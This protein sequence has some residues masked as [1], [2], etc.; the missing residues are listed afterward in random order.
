VLD[1]RN[2]STG[3]P[4]FD[5]NLPVMV[6]NWIRLGFVSVDYTKNLSDGSKYDWL[7]DRPEMT[8]QPQDSEDSD[9]LLQW[10][11]GILYR[12][13]FGRQFARAVGVLQ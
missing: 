7:S 11:K 10:D 13:E 1:L 5:A 2:A 4:V 6:D 3:E 12:T 8:G 9:F